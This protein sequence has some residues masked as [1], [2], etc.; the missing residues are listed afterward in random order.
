MYN[1]AFVADDEE[2]IREFL[3]KILQRR[4]YS[5]MVSSEGNEARDILSR[6]EFDLIFLDYEIPGANGFELVTVAR[7]KNPEATI[8]VFTGHQAIDGRIADDLGANAFLQKPL[9]IKMIEDILGG[10][11]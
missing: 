4:G 1:N 8:I 5:V 11:E 3:K 6:R 9:S 10:I 7:E 2:D